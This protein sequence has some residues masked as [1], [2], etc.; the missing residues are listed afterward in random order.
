MGAEMFETAGRLWRL[1]WERAMLERA[2]TVLTE[3]TR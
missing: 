3:R 1:R 2:R